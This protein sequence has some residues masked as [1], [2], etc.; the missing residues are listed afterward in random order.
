[1]KNTQWQ[2]KSTQWQGKSTQWQGKS[3]QRE[4]KNKQPQGKNKKRWK[5]ARTRRSRGSR[6][7]GVDRLAPART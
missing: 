1:G 4:G 5:A 7:P 2:G 6:P 3:T